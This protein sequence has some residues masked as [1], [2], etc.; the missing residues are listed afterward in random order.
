[1]RP[2]LLKFVAAY[3]AYVVFLHAVPGPWQRW[4]KGENVDNWTW[5]HVLWGAIAKRM[6][7]TAGELAVLVAA[8]E[9]IEA[10]ARAKR[11]DLLFG[12]PEGPGNV[13]VD[14]GATMAAFYATPSPAPR[15]RG[16][17]R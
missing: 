12:S 10:V 4:P 8:N 1:M 7:V 13:W 3:G 5:T 15:G 14:V 6:G 17:Q 9:G 16:I 11:P 2:E